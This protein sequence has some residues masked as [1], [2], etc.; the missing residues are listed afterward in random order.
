VLVVVV[1]GTVVDVD[2]EALDVEDPDDDELAEEVI[3]VNA[4][5]STT[6]TVAAGSPLSGVSVVSPPMWAAT[7][8]AA[9]WPPLP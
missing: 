7:V 4:P 3:P 9:A 1:E 8:W 6:L 2:V 5:R